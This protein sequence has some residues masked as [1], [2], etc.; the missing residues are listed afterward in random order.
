[1]SSPFVILTAILL[2]FPIF[3]VEWANLAGLKPTGNAVKVEGMLGMHCQLERRRIKITAYIAD[4]PSYC[5][6]LA[7]CRSLVGLTLD[8]LSLLAGQKYHR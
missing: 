7:G 8:A 4:S 5:T 1:L 6:L 3:V 2:E